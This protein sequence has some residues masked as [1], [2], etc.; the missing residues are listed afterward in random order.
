MTKPLGFIGLGRMGSPM[1]LNLIRAEYKLAVYDLNPKAVEDLV[2]A[3]AAKKD[4]VAELA[5]NSDTVITMLPADKEIMAVYTGTEGLLENLKEGAVCIDMTS[6]TGQAIK[7]VAAIASQKGIRIIDAPV[8]GGVPGAQSG[9]LTIM[10]GGEKNLVDE[11]MPILKV[12]GSRIFYTGDVGSGKSVKMI[13]QFLNAGN[14]YIASEA[15]VLAKKMG[16][17]LDILCSIVNESSGGSWI[18]KNTVPNSI[19]PEKFDAGFK[20]DLMKKDVSLSVQQ[21]QRD[22]LSLPGLALIHQ[23]YQAVSN[24]G[25]G[26]KTYSYV[27][28]WVESLNKP[29]QK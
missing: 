2:K 21:A 10:V 8:S 26:D 28:K 16:L 14:T 29:E 17:D 13:N 18:F 1:A 20:L 12:M 19:I 24:Q 11:Y 5:G 27:S 4:S 23:I 25:N 3:G 9:A 6:A 22:N 15:L 7:D